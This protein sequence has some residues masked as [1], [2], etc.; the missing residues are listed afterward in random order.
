M[1]TGQSGWTGQ[2]L[3]EVQSSL[4]FVLSFFPVFFS[5]FRD[6]SISIILSL[7]DPSFYLAHRILTVPLSYDRLSLSISGTMAANWSCLPRLS[8][9]ASHAPR[10]HLPFTVASKTLARQTEL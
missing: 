7:G 9:Q 4:L 6:N 10:L 5:P 1:S 3:C 2:E 8:I